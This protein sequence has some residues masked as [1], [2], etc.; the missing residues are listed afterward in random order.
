M[1]KFLKDTSGNIAISV[2]LL[3]IPLVLAAGVA[4]DYSEFSRNQSSLQNATDAATLAVAHDLQKNT[5]TEIEAKVDAY[6][7]SNLSEQQYSEVQSVNVIIG[8]A[9]EKVSVQAVSTYPTALMHLAGIP[10]LNYAPQSVINVPTGNIEIVM[11]LDTTDSMSLDGKMDALKISASQ[12]V[13]D[14]MVS[15]AT[16]ERAKIG[17]VPFARY[18]NVGLDN[19]DAPWIDV[20]DDYTATETVQKQDIISSSNCSDQTVPNSEG[21][22]ETRNICENVT[23]GAPYDVQE[24][25]DYEW[26]GCAGSRNYPLNLNDENYSNRVPGL[27][28][29]YCPNRIT[30][31][32]TDEDKLKNEIDSLAPG[33]STYIP[34]GLIWGL[35]T[36]SG[37]A[38]FDDGLSY[39]EAN[40]KNTQK[41]LVIMSDG[42]NQSSINSDNRSKHNGAHLVQANQYTREACDYI[43]AQ[44]VTIYTIGFGSAIP[45]ATLDMLKECSTD[46]VNYY[47]AADGAALSAA[48]TNIT[49]QLTNLYISK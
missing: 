41:A 6:L 3:A 38:P 24:T 14:V 35:R 17:I 26:R 39:A 44:G 1:K 48:F 27:L 16:R 34:T 15:N 30:E 4:V 36:L 22:L 21:V 10:T 19:R 11:V 25:R 13:E 28:N 32:S 9:K 46:G 18:V 37:N 42:E 2:S 31:L 47:N 12:F 5:Q 7:K 23:Y 49:S 45:Q 29:T 43:K 8:P 20:P 33:G 40:Q